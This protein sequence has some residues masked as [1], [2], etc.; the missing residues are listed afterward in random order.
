[1]VR[2]MRRMECSDVEFKG[3][4]KFSGGVE[5]G[6]ADLQEYVKHEDL[7]YVVKG[8]KSELEKMQAEN[9]T[10]KQDK[11]ILKAENDA[12]QIQNAELRAQL[13][14]QW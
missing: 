3:D 8:L 4:V 2:S 9:L 11:E 6:G 10:L 7:P 12:L 1:M 13:E 5:V 14:N